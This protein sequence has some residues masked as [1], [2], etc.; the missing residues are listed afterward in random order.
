MQCV[1]TLTRALLHQAMYR[2]AYKGL[3]RAI[4]QSDVDCGP[5][6]AFTLHAVAEGLAPASI[7]ISLVH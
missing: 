5:F 3:A 4:V 2:N 7:E 1:G 6:T